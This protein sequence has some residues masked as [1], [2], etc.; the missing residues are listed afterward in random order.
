MD[1]SEISPDGIVYNLKDATAR[2]ALTT[3][4]EHVD[5]EVE[6][7]DERI[8]Q[9]G[10]AVPYDTNERDTGVKWIDGRP[11]YSKTF[12][13]TGTT[14]ITNALPAETDEI[15]EIRGLVGIG[16]ANLMRQFGLFSS[17]SG[18]APLVE[19]PNIKFNVTGTPSI[20]KWHL[21]VYYTKSTD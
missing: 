7:L 6:R 11:V 10:G 1:I 16:T 5:S 17:S 2:T 20:R 18:V 12:T 14:T 4:S 8:D 9:A 19:A 15:V 21:T 3:L 13:G